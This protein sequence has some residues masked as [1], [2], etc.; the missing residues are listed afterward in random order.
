M[1][2]VGPAQDPAELLELGVEPDGRGRGS[3][4]VEPGDDRAM[5]LEVAAQ[6][7]DR[8]GLVQRL[9]LEDGQHVLRGDPRLGQPL[10]GPSGDLA[11]PRRTGPEVR[12]ILDRQP[13][14]LGE[15]LHDGAPGFL[16]RLVR[17]EAVE[18]AADLHPGRDRIQPGQPDVPPV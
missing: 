2:A 11:M 17:L 12:Q 7:L 6:R 3:L 1:P 15:P 9:E 5:P 13:L 14:E 4:A 18:V 16:G 8:H 10:P